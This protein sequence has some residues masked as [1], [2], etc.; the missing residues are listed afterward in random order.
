[1]ILTI[2][3]K[4]LLIRRAMVASCPRMLAL[5]SLRILGLSRIFR[6]SLRVLLVRSEA[7]RNFLNAL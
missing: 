7:E 2:K 3:E 4:A 1:M 6:S 5:C